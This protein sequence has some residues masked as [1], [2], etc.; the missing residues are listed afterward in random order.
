MPPFWSPAQ[1][2]QPW[3]P[4]ELATVPSLAS[5]WTPSRTRPPPSPK[6]PPSPPGPPLTPTPPAP[7]TSPPRSG[8]SAAWLARCNG[9]AEVGGS[10]PLAPTI[11]KHLPSAYLRA[12]ARAG[13]AATGTIEKVARNLLAPWR[14]VMT[15]KALHCAVTETV[16]QSRRSA[17]ACSASVASMIPKPTHGSQPSSPLGCEPDAC[18]PMRY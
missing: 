5:S 17:D 9:V 3:A 10:N 6:H 11:S 7:I 16:G 2:P 14:S 4:F 13:R 18:S 12:P 1:N 8:R 15:K